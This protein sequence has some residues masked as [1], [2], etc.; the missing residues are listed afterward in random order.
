MTKVII[1][2]L[3]LSGNKGGPAILASLVTRLRQYLDPLEVIMVST[4]AGDREWQAHY[5]IDRI[6]QHPVWQLSRPLQFPRRLLQSRR[7]YK[8]G[9]LVIDMT[10]VKF[11]GGRGLKTAKTHL[12]SASH[13]FFPKSYHIPVAVFTQTYGPFG[14]SMTRWFARRSLG[15]ADL[16]FARE[17]QSMAQLATIGLAEKATL[18]PDVAFLLPTTP[19]ENIILSESVRSFVHN[20][21]PFIGF[22]VSN[23][24]ILEEKELGLTARYEQLATQLLQWLLDS[25]H[26]VLLIPHSYQPNSPAADDFGLTSR[27]FQQLRPADPQQCILVKD[28]LPPEDLKTLI[29][30]AEVFIGSR[31]HSVI[32]A[33]SSGRPSMAIGWSHKYDGLFNLFEMEHFCFSAAEVSLSDLQS[34]LETLLAEQRS[35]QERIAQRL[36]GILAQVDESVRRVAA[37]IQAVEY[38]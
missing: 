11:V 22:S 31:Y 5:G 37:L 19:L 3:S 24:V 33:L 20:P 35:Y 38:E 2:G 18:Y 17:P 25:G 32:A 36:P 23:K 13:I 21:Q 26:R 12:R 1:V 9:D 29:A 15:A 30:R 28:D 6:I 27:I 8:D 7:L 16:I 4:Y 34:A 14:D 10:G